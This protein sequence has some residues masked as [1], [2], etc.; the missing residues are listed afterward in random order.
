[1]YFI[2]LV[3]GIVHLPRRFLSFFFFLMIRRPPRSTLSSSS[4]ASDVYKRQPFIDVKGVRGGLFM[5]IEPLP[6]SLYLRKIPAQDV[7]FGNT[8]RV[9]KKTEWVNVLEDDEPKPKVQ[10]STVEPK[11]TAPLQSSLNVADKILSDLLQDPETVLAMHSNPALKKVFR[12]CLESPL[13]GLA[14]MNDPQ[15]AP[16]AAKIS[17]AASALPG[18]WMQF[19]AALVSAN[20]KKVLEEL[21]M[22]GPS[23]SSEGM[24]SGA[25]QEDERMD[26]LM[27]DDE[28]LDDLVLDL[29]ELVEW[30]DL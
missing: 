9:R 4:A 18:G 1:M 16:F 14:Y 20:P 21:G 15:M 3:H 26:E 27:C 23:E 5:A 17:A 29:R 28:Y 24:N 12:E 7:G 10:P 19:A 25:S 13:K 8:R 6:D 22:E 11:S 2:L 30:A